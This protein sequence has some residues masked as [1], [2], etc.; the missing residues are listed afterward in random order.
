MFTLLR[1][2]L[3]V[4]Q[5][6]F[7]R[8]LQPHLASFIQLSVQHLTALAPHFEA[9]YLSS[10]DGAPEPPS[11]PNPEEGT[12]AGI[13]DLGASIM[14]FLT[15][16]SRARSVRAILVKR[17]IN[18]AAGA[19]AAM[20]NDSPTPVFEALVHQIVG[21][22]RITREDVRAAKVCWNSLQVTHA[23]SLVHSCSAG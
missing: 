16:V 4:L 9:F 8:V 2:T 1:Q 13:V 22:A 18:N 11:S 19:G 10:A 7:P 20:G 15:G 12:N 21:W 17:D 14:D 23:Q 3:T 5:A 6:S